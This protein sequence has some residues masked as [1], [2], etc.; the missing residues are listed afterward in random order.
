MKSLKARE[1]A[2]YEIE[3]MFLETAIKETQTKSEASIVMTSVT[4]GLSHICVDWKNGVRNQAVDK[5][6]R[7]N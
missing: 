6:L 1:S 4:D 2:I 5:M 3:N 7:M